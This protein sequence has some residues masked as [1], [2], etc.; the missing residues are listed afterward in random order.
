MTLALEAVLPA[1]E[2][3]RELQ[4]DYFRCLQ[5]QDWPALARLFTDDADCDMRDGP[6]PA[7]APEA[8]LQGRDAIVDYI[9]RELAPLEARLEGL[10]RGIEVLSPVSARACWMLEDRV[11]ARGGRPVPF[12]QLS[13]WGRLHLT[14]ARVE[15]CWRIRSLRLER[16]WLRVEP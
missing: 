2:E 1:Q 10:S 16:L 6:G 11:T 13:G 9:A 4:A 8:L 3:I 12:R 15:G 5:S 7:G 14:Y